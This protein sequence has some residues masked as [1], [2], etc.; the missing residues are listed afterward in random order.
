M[1]STTTDTSE[2]PSIGDSN[3]EF[4]AESKSIIYSMISPIEVA[5]REP[6]TAEKLEIL[7][8]IPILQADY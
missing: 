7:T 5:E 2:S 6:S 1:I 8:V 4:H 3:S